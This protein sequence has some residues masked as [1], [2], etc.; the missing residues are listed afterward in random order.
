[1]PGHDNNGSYADPEKEYKE[2]LAYTPSNPF[3][4]RND[5]SKVYERL[6]EVMER[7]DKIHDGLQELKKSYGPE[8]INGIWR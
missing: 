1:M 3:E 5:Q 8:L 2:L 7:L 4:P 6:K